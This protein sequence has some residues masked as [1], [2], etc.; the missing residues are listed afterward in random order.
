MA[1]ADELPEQ[2][3]PE[4]ALNTAHPRSIVLGIIGLFILLGLWGLWIKQGADDGVKP[5][6]AALQTTPTPPASEHATLDFSLVVYP[7]QSTNDIQAALETGFCAMVAGHAADFF[8]YYGQRNDLYYSIKLTRVQVYNF[9]TFSPADQADLLTDGD[10]P[11]LTR[12]LSVYRNI[13]PQTEGVMALRAL[14]GTHYL[15]VVGANREELNALYQPNLEDVLDEW[16]TEGAVG[17]WHYKADVSMMPLGAELGPYYS[18]LAYT[19]TAEDWPLLSYAKRYRQGIVLAVIEQ[20]QLRYGNCSVRYPEVS[21]PP[22]P[23]VTPSLSEPVNDVPPAPPLS[24][25]V[26]LT[27]SISLTPSAT[28]TPSPTSTASATATPS[29][30]STASATITPSSTASNTSTTTA[31]ATASPTNT[32]TATTTASTVPTW[33]PSSTHTSSPTATNTNTPTLTWT[34]SSTPA[35]TATS[36]PTETDTP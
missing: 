30:T 19:L 10:A 36:T 4:Q 21:A 33:T 17:V 5:A 18:A 1:F 14:Q 27:P 24:P 25:T 13:N 29:S 2:S 20:R 8:P 31:T 23:T 28:F 15:G 34:P 22:R 6:L 26:S 7:D 9:A 32:N 3:H 16:A 11:P 12:A 35:N